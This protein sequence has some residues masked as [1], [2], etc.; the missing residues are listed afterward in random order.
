[1][2]LETTGRLFQSGD[3]LLGPPSIATTNSV[4]QLGGAGAV[5]GG[6]AIRDSASLF[7]IKREPDWSNAKIDYHYVKTPDLKL[8]VAPQW[9]SNAGDR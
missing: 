5:P 2:S 3:T 6:S 8:T 9:M 7:R 1:M 4:A